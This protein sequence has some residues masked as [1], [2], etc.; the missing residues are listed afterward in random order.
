LHEAGEINLLNDFLY[1]NNVRKRYRDRERRI[2]P[3][4]KCIE[5]WHMIP[6]DIYEYEII[7]VL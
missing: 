2:V 7:K 6:P 4:E 3:G 5:A 1:S